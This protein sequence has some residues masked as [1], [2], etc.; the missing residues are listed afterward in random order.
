MST[1]TSPFLSRELSVLRFN[2][3]VLL[4]AS[5]PEV[6]LLERFRF[7]CILSRNLDEFFEIR[8]SSLKQQTQ[9][10][11]HPHMIFPDGATPRALLE[12]ISQ[13]AHRLVDAQYE[14]FEQVL[15]ELKNQQIFFLK[16]EAWSPE[17]RQFVKDY[18][19]QDILPV[20]T[21][22]ALD[23]THPF[24]KLVNKSTNFIVQL[25][26]K[27]AFGRNSGLAVI[28]PPP[29]LGRLLKLPSARDECAST[30]LSEIIQEHA[31]AL[32]SGMKIQGCYPF[33]LTRNSD[34]MVDA[35][36][37]DDLA[38]VLKVE[39]LSRRY[40]DT[41]RLEVAEQTPQS[42]I[43]FLLKKFQLS[44]DEL[45]KIRGPLNLTRLNALFDWV[46]ASAL[47]FPPFTPKKPKRLH[48]PS[49]LFESIAKKDR[50]LHHPYQS[51]DPVIEFIQEAA[52]DP[53]VLAI[54]QTLYRIDTHSQVIDA[55]LSAASAGKEVTV[56]IELMAR[57]DEADNLALAS[58]LQEAGAIVVYGVVGHKT[59]AKMTW[60][61]RREGRQ[62]KHYTHLSTGNYHAIKAQYYTDFSLFTA[63]P[64]IGADI[65]QIFQQLTGMGRASQLSQVIQ[66]PF[67]LAEKIKYW[68][69][70]EI[71]NIQNGHPARIMAK[72]NALTDPEL[73]QCLYQASRA[74][75]TIDLVIRGMCSLKPGVPGL[76]ENI[77]VYSAIGRFLEHSRVYFFQNQNDPL[78]YLSSADWME[79]NLYHRVEICFPV[80]DPKLKERVIQE[81]LL[82]HIGT[83]SFM[84]KPD[85]NY[86]LPA[87]QITSIT[88]D[89]LLKKWGQP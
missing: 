89:F 13:Q 49:S 25:K 15:N 26:G 28:H 56:V 84:L 61:L 67:H 50:L 8:I 86:Q 38:Q 35:L 75:V 11:P 66:A 47:Y 55:L 3:R 16:R 40:G 37:T 57:F 21:P 88:Q 10:H 82:Q 14:A 72:L 20:L 64:N 73:I 33:R 34:L 1:Q 65:Q 59:H 43:D 7:L 22:I 46:L 53:K 39:L 29:N 27:D 12:E 77:R 18:F 85:G 74:G 9:Q 81:G 68:I 87:S 19:E 79:R 44:P 30:F 60:V 76:S 23:L 51:F 24:P 5:A 4:C 78:V 31:A 54:K 36:N 63:D 6:P 32:F 69:Q 45:Y 70:Q 41:V 42:I 58:S 71:Q 83:H 48:A 17:Q 2:E 52:K 62:L 80:R